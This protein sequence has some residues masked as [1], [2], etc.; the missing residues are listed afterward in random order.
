MQIQRQANT[1]PAPNSTLNA[2]ANPLIHAFIPLSK[3]VFFAPTT[4]E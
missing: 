3:Y 4:Q 1:K 2:R